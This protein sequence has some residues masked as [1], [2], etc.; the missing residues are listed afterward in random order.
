MEQI[1]A[2]VVIVG[3]GSAGVGAAYRLSRAE[4][5]I[6]VVVLEKN[7]GLGGMS[8]FG[9]V[10]CWEPGIG[11]SGVHTRLAGA[12]L[13]KPGAACVGRQVEF[14]GHDIRWGISR[15]CGG[16]YRS[17]LRRAGL[18]ETDWRRFHFEPEQMEQAMRSLFLQ[19]P[20]VQ[21]F[22]ET[23]LCGAEIADGRIC[24]VSAR[25]R[26]GQELQ[27]TAP[28]FLD[29]S[30]DIVLA[31]MAG[32][33][34]RCGEESFETFREPSAPKENLPEQ[35]NGVSI[36]FRA[37]KQGDSI[38]REL[39]MQAERLDVSEWMREWV[40]SGRLLSQINEYPNGDL[41]VNM[42][43]TMEGAEYMRLGTQQAVE[44]CRARIWQYWC[45]LREKRRFSGYHIQSIFPMPGIRESWRLE[46][47]YVLKEQDI[48]AGLAQQ[49]LRSHV[50]ALADHALD[51][52]G[53]TN[54]KG[55][56]C[57]ELLQPYGIPYECMLPREIN[58]LLVACRGCSMSHIAASSA[59]LSR[60]MIALGE[61][62]GEASVLCILQRC[63]YREISVQTL[64]ERLGLAAFER[65]LAA[66]NK[67]TEAEERA[68][69]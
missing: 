11:G 31:R 24:C 48:R 38:E 56:R 52:H 17:T 49:P 20:G 27:I 21:F 57:A 60:T 15:Q 23:E 4:Q 51:T 41:N 54:I 67:N 9:G 61:A 42:L 13:E 22:F 18:P 53:A 44:I 6:R 62:A 46:G 47:A 66:Q 19:A 50:V 35:V 8:V 12:L 29:C 30:A 28:L 1:R 5:L 43:P 33:R 58:N 39:A 16:T 37:V 14:P 2:D 45:W 68:I 64:R 32:C 55:A 26:D 65:E 7:S 59:R 34:T 25:R 40:L 36:I 63:S 69:P 3:G 10:N